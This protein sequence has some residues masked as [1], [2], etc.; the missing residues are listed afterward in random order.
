MPSLPLFLNNFSSP[1]SNLTVNVNS[2]AQMNAT[3]GGHVL[4]LT[5]ANVTLNNSGTLD[6]SL[7]GLVS[8]LSGGAFIG[9]GVVS[10]VSVLNNTSGIMRGTGGL[11]GLNLTSLDGVALG[12]NNAGGGTTSITNNGTITVQAG[13]KSFTGPQVS[14]YPMPQM[15][16]TVCVE[17]LMSAMRSGS[18]IAALS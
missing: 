15:P 2:G 12:V 11:L 13:K 18:P 4:D 1:S 5:G 17:C 14:N 9:N 3:L 16:K 7:L 8:V 10:A 6:P